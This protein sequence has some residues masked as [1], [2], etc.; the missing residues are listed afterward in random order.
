MSGGSLIKGIG[1]IIGS[2]NPL[3]GA[4]GRAN[5]PEQGETI[6]GQ[7]PAIMRSAEE[8][9]ERSGIPL[10]NPTEYQR[11]DRPFAEMAADY[12]DRMPH[13]PNDYRTKQAY[14]ALGTETEAQFEQMLR[15]GVKPYLFSDKDPYPNSPYQALQ[16][17][18]ENQRLGVFSTRAGFGSN[19]DFDPSG[20]PL[21]QEMDYEIDGQPIFL[22]DAFRAVHDYYGHG[23][24]GFGFRAGGEENAFQAHSGMFSDLARQA[25][26]TETRGQNS[27]L[28]Y[29]PHGEA[30]RTARLE[31]TKFADQKTGLL[32]NLISTG[33]TPISDERRRRIDA[34]A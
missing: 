27:W 30:N 18:Y 10:R 1:N 28:N 4:P 17:I 13:N 5:I 23:K 33:R 16:D 12:Y 24:H 8:Y 31:D 6:V 22:N 2:R 21:L 11:I 34:D 9:A 32:P 14:D 19:A 15:D 26:A 7:N 20:N 29:G 3:R 25:A